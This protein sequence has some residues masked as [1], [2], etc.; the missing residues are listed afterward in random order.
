M[1]KWQSGIQKE[2]P[3]D[4]SILKGNNMKTRWSSQS[5]LTKGRSGA[6]SVNIRAAIK[7]RGRHMNEVESWAVLCGSVQTLQDKLLQING[8]PNLS[9]FEFLLIS[10]EKLRLTFEGNVEIERSG[11]NEVE[12]FLHPEINNLC[13]IRSSDI[14]K[15]AIYSLGKTISQ[16]SLRTK[17]M[18]YLLERMTSPKLESVPHLLS[19]M[20]EVEKYWREEVGST[21]V[22]QL[23]AQLCQLTL[24]SRPSAVAKKDV[25]DKGKRGLKDD[26]KDVVHYNHNKMK[27]KDVH[28]SK[29][30]FSRLNTSSSSDSTDDLLSSSSSLPK[31]PQNLP[32]HSLDSP[33]GISMPTLLDTNDEN[34]NN[35]FAQNKK[36]TNQRKYGKRLEF[37]PP[38]TQ[39]LQR[40][41]LPFDSNL[42][43][44]KSY[45]ANELSGLRTM[46]KEQKPSTRSLL[47]ARR[48]YRVVKPVFSR[49][50]EDR[51]RCIGPEFVV[52]SG[53]PVIKLDLTEGSVKACT[54]LIVLLT[55]QKMEMK[56]DPLVNTVNQ[57]L[58]ISSEFLRID[59]E[60]LT[61]FS[62]MLNNNGEW[63]YLSP[64]TRMTKI[65]PNASKN[66]E[67]ICSLTLYQRFFLFPTCYDELND[68]YTCHLLYL[69]LR[70]DTIEGLYRA[71]V[72][73]QL[74]MAS[75]A[76][77][78]EFGT[79]SDDI[80]GSGPY[81]LPQHYLPDNVRTLLG[82]REAREMLEK[83]HKTKEADDLHNAQRSF[84]H[85]IMALKDYG[86]FFYT[87]R[88]T[89]KLD[90]ASTFFA[91][92]T[93]GVFFFEISK[94]VFKPPKEIYKFDWRAIKE[95]Q[96]SS[97]KM[98]FTLLGDTN[99]AKFK[100][101]LPE[102][103]TKHVFDI[104]ETYHK[105]HIFKMQT[106]LT[107][108]CAFI[109]SSKNDT[110][111]T[112]CRKVKRYTKESSTKKIS[113]KRLSLP[114][115]GRNTLKRSTSTLGDGQGGEEHRYTIRRLTHYTSM[116]GSN[117][118]TE[119]NRKL[120]K[121][122]T[123]Y[124][125]HYRYK[126]YLEN[127]D[128]ECNSEMET[129][130]VSTADILDPEFFDIEDEKENN[131]PSRRR[132]MPGAAL[133]TL[134][135]TNINLSNAQ[136]KRRV[137]SVR[138]GTKVSA[139]ALNRERLRTITKKE[140]LIPDSHNP[141]M[142]S[143]TNTSVRPPAWPVTAPSSDSEDPDVNESLSMSLLE[144]F[145]QM[146]T[147]EGEPER[148]IVN[149][150]MVKDSL[151]RLGIKISGTPS[152]IYVDNIDSNIA[153]IE[154]G[155]LT[156]G[157]RII[158]VNNRSLENVNYYSA[159]D[160]IRSSGD[161]IQFLVSQMR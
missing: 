91:V 117:K 140:D 96:Y 138:M 75:I 95:I 22:S 148:R 65:L 24:G 60:D 40:R 33:F 46:P 130:N 152:G 82:E 45:S 56:I 2:D 109:K 136:T 119:T 121:D 158:A 112:F 25:H 17:S 80:H 50:P 154:V 74:S 115:V 149:I 76:M 38:L 142:L 16:T 114:A 58:E 86:F 12:K 62:L 48:L 129:D 18:E 123:D 131:P 71:D 104:T 111:R 43:K 103:K 7:V 141:P 151:G 146:E 66:K 47:N 57:L 156:V 70:Q 81:F 39:K 49:S 116:A 137:S 30:E 44:S 78:S 15:L 161:K 23:I 77:H 19:V 98:Q 1:K 64:D 101:Y 68:P 100:I 37:K 92:H 28:Q 102:F 155:D 128:D 11:I 134:P 53:Q 14:E 135:Q 126:V 63:L 55:G 72:S 144:R 34:R 132:S 147:E 93:T 122:T 124:D 87:G 153:T 79:Y 10:P 85:Q 150:L 52:M 83:L 160:I 8:R 143:T 42:D 27:I 51:E 110:F 120:D 67:G 99:N 113:K 108:N 127:E 73:V 125:K 32:S 133:N 20:R 139:H 9:N 159:L 94:N 69:Q 88:E 89:K 41:L 106:T 59:T 61:R 107:D 84:C 4:Q 118:E 36:I 26:A 145:D 5:L 29:V 31:P 90:S 54:V 157:D 105:Q 97:T 13:K 35:I 21:P 6:L 3:I